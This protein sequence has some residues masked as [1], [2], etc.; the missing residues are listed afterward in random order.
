[1]I[2]KTSADQKHEHGKEA[3]SNSKDDS[4]PEDTLVEPDGDKLKM[5]RG[6]RPEVEVD[7]EKLKDLF[8]YD[9]LGNKIRFIDIYEKQKTI[10]VFTRVRL[11]IVLFRNWTVL[12]DYSI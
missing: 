11:H 6:L 7:F 1:M 3:K 9:E 5:S 8:V 12:L 10:I 4:K 2:R